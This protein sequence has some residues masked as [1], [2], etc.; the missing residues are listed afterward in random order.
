MMNDSRIRTFTGKLFDPIHPDPSLICIEDIAHAL[1]LLNRFCGH[2][3]V[4]YTVGQ[5]CIYV[6][7]MVEDPLLRLPALLH[8]ASEAYLQDI[9]R[10]IKYLPMMAPYRE[11]EKVLE[12]CI[13]EKFHVE[14]PWHPLIGISDRRMLV[15]EQQALM[16]GHKIETGGGVPLWEP[17][18]H[19]T[20]RSLPSTTVEQ[21]Y[22]KEFYHWQK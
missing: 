13:A 2:T 20:I 15:T 9:P 1:S 7:N 19:L 21:A 11:A 18:P 14:F 4:P 5:H 3:T 12:A 6:S 22:L 17:F 16:Y 10:P 8:D